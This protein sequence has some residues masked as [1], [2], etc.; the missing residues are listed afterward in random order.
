VTVDR[1]TELV[2]IPFGTGYWRI[3]YRGGCSTGKG[4]MSFR[5]AMLIGCG[6]TETNYYIITLLTHLQNES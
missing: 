5:S 6:A 4:N 2:L 3:E 1:P